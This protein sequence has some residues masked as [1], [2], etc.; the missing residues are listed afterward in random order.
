M[1]LLFL[2]EMLSSEMST[3]R[4]QLTVLKYERRVESRQFREQKQQAWGPWGGSQRRDAKK[5]EA[6][7]TPLS[8]LP[9][10]FPSFPFFFLSSVSS[11]E[12]RQ[13]IFDH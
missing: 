2:S 3:L 8:F 13:L 11:F 1:S 6:Q 12:I 9:S 4:E 7:S 10:L 5:E